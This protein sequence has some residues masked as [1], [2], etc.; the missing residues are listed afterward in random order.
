MKPVAA[1]TLGRCRLQMIQLGKGRDGASFYEK[2]GLAELPLEE[3]DIAGTVSPNTVFRSP[4]RMP[5]VEDIVVT[6]IE[7]QAGDL[8]LVT[9]LTRA[10]GI[11]LE[12]S[13]GPSLNVRRKFGLNEE[14][15]FGGRGPRLAQM[16]HMRRYTAQ[17]ACRYTEFTESLSFHVC[18]MGVTQTRG[19]GLGA[20]GLGRVVG[21]ALARWSRIQPHHVSPGARWAL[22]PPR[23]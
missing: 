22:A 17:P 10:V 5:A 19:S 14:F 12:M 20:W 15:D 21:V 11:G 7:V 2:A 1:P 18:A 4:E 23:E 8:V 13:P 6:S 9:E 3:H 16:H